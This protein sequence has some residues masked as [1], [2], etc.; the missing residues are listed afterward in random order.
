[1]PFQRS[2]FERIG[3]RTGKL[4]EFDEI[5]RKALEERE[6]RYKEWKAWRPNPV[7]PTTSRGWL[8]SKPRNSPAPIPTSTEGTMV[9]AYN[10][11]GQRR[12]TTI[13]L[14]KHSDPSRT[15]KTCKSDDGS[16]LPK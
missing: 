16:A 15:P 9:D 11:A 12:G 14:I 7:P 1:M 5:A 13:R 8:R 10:R 3:A 6:L 2:Y 4:E